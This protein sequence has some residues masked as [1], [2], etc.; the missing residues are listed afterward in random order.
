[1]AEQQ[2]YE[3]IEVKAADI[4]AERQQMWAGFGTFITW[5]L[6]SIIV[7]LLAIYAIWG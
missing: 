7:I 4:L 1:M 5:S 3:F 6:G 2:T